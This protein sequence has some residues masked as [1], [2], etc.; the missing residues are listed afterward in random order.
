MEG[1]SFVSMRYVHFTLGGFKPFIEK[2]PYEI[3]VMTRTQ[4]WVFIKSGGSLALKL[5]GKIVVLSGEGSINS[6]RQSL[7]ALEE[8]ATYTISYDQLQAIGAAKTIEFRI[9][10]NNQTITGNLKPEGVLSF[11]Y[12]A[13]KAP[14]MIGD[15]SKKSD[16]IAESLTPEAKAAAEAARLASE[17]AA[18]VRA[19]ANKPALLA[20]IAE[21]NE[22]LAKG[23]AVFGKSDL[24]VSGLPVRDTLF[25]LED[26]T[27]VVVQIDISFTADFRL[28][29]IRDEYNANRK[30]LVYWRDAGV[31]ELRFRTKNTEGSMF[32]IINLQAMK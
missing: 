14:E 10:G 23:G 11:Q 5:D 9:L 7:G 6:R 21:A 30:A 4:E 1:G 12:F 28:K 26:L 24:A 19:E 27:V 25:M 3:E 22:S 16:P 17:A 31:T 8:H 20:K 15:P 2:T 29:T 32:K 18:K 13:Q